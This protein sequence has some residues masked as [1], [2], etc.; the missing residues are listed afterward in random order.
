MKESVNVAYMYEDRGEE[1]A[2]YHNIEFVHHTVTDHVEMLID[3]K[4]AVTFSDM[5]FGDF[6]E[7]V[8]KIGSCL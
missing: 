1:K 5:Y 8:D 3:G 7:V 2:I 6:K 4:S